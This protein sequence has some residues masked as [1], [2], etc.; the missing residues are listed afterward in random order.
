MPQVCV[1][2]ELRCC[3]EPFEFG[4]AFD[5]FIRLLDQ[6]GWD[7]IIEPQSVCREN[8]LEDALKYGLSSEDVDG[9]IFERTI[10]F[11]VT[12]FYEFNGYGNFSHD[13]RLIHV[14]EYISAEHARNAESGFIKGNV[15][16]W[17]RGDNPE[18]IAFL[19]QHYGQ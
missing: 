1:C 18:I 4:A 19:L 11:L 15:V 7:Y 12:D 8:V 17:Y 6:T 10:E 14:S 3:V 16:V 9:V 2:D 13:W 5:D